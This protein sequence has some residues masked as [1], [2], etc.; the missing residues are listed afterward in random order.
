MAKKRTP[1]ATPPAAVRRKRPGQTTLTLGTESLADLDTIRDILGRE[2]GLS[3]EVSRSE[4]LRA[5]IVWFIEDFRGR[6]QRAAIDKEKG[7]R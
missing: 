2:W 3:Q 5:L 4:T 1:P 7:D 6:S